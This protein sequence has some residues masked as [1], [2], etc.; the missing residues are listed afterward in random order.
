MSEWFFVR[1]GLAN[2]VMNAGT[3]VGGLVLPLILPSIIQPNGT[4]ITLRYLA[5]AVFASLLAVGSGARW[6]TNQSFWLILV[7]TTLQGFAY[8]L[9]ILYLPTFAKDMNMNEEQASLALAL[10]NG[11]S[12]VSRISLGQLS[13]I[14]NPWLLTTFTLAGTSIFTFVLW[15][16]VTTNMATLSIYAVIFGALA[17]GFSSLWT[18]FVRPI[19][20][21]DPISATTML[22]MLMLSRGLGNV[23]STPVSSA[24]LTGSALNYVQSGF[25]HGS[26]WTRLIVY[27]GAMFAGA[28]MVGLVGWKRERGMSSVLLHRTP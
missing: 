8:F 5:V 12:V 9:P 20:R 10:L 19:A 18:G 24:L 13:D 2:G 14:F 6:S 15:G 23:L 11:S 28:A 1:R 16:A 21:D 4:Q 26:R 27:I 7:V 25:Q 17:G 22:G 3:A